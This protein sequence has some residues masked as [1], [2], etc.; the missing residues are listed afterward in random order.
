MKKL[1]IILISMFYM[2]S[3][4][5]VTKLE[6][7]YCLQ[8]KFKKGTLRGDIYDALYFPLSISARDACLSS[9]GLD[10]AG[11]RKMC[12]QRVDDWLAA[13]ALAAKEDRKATREELRA[14]RLALLA[15]IDQMAIEYETAEGDDEHFIPVEEPEI[16]VEQ[17]LEFPEV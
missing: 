6:F 10:L 16:P 9:L 12:Q 11:V 13:M 5:E 14:A 3:F 2:S 8:V 15:Q 7:E 1:L 17:P 4:A